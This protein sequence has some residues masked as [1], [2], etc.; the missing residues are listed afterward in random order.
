MPIN[1]RKS[2]GCKVTP[3]LSNTKLLSCDQPP[4]AVLVLSCFFKTLQVA[5]KFG[6][7]RQIASVKTF[8]LVDAGA[9]ILSKAVDV[10][11]TFAER[12]SH[13]DCGVTKGIQRVFVFGYRILLQRTQIQL[14]LP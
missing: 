11:V 14:K 6:G 9:C 2:R 4:I 1:V 10:Y 12:Q 5:N 13:A 7:K 8:D 3:S